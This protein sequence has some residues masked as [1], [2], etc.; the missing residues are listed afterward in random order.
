VGRPGRTEPADADAIGARKELA[1]T[2]APSTVDDQL[3]EIRDLLFGG[4]AAWKVQTPGG[5]V[6][7]GA[8][9]RPVEPANEPKPQ[10]RGGAA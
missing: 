8:P 6:V 1:E 3:A 2:T 7:G 4:D 10:L 5:G 9:A